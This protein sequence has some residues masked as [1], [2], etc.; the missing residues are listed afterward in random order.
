[1][2]GKQVVYCSIS[3]ILSL[4]FRSMGSKSRYF[5]CLKFRDSPNTHSATQKI[6]GMAD[7]VQY[8]KVEE[9]AVHQPHSSNGT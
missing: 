6:Y 1:M 3:Y 2:K 7:D 5:G 4:V 9:Y 8:L